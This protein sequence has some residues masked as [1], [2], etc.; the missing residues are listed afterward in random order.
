MLPNALAPVL[1]L[2]MGAA[3]HSSK[4]SSCSLEEYPES[5]RAHHAVSTRK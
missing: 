5:I 2:H 4:H 1:C 3:A